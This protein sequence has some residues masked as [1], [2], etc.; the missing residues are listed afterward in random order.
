MADPDYTRP[1]YCIDDQ[2]MLQQGICHV[3]NQTPPGWADGPCD[4]RR[5]HV[6]KLRRLHRFKN[7][8]V[9]AMIDVDSTGDLHDFFNT[10]ND[11]AEECGY[12]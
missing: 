9:T 4:A 8:V 5:M 3:K 10:V 2:G 11:L 1:I 12:A 6:Q 7:A